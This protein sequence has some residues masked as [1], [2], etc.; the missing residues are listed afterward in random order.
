[1]TGLGPL[2]IERSCDACHDDGARGHPP[3]SAGE[4]SPSF[5]MQ[6]GGAGSTYG[7]VLNTQAIDGHRPEGRITVTLHARQE[8]YRDGQRWTLHEPRYAVHD[9][10]HGPLAANVVLKPRIGPALF[11]V[12]LLDAVPQ[13]A[14]ESIRDSQPRRV[15]GRMAGRF[16]WQGDAISLVDQ[17]AIAFA[18]EMGLTSELVPQDDCTPAQQACLDAAG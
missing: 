8:R 9:L 5:V 7:H 17:T 14:V 2:F 15:R 16:G 10:A 4:P 18:R 12:G 11:G 13:A 1:N 3:P 6:L